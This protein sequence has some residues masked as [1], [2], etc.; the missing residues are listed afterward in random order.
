MKDKKVK[1]LFCPGISKRTHLMGF[2]SSLPSYSDAWQ[3]NFRSNIWNATTVFYVSYIIVHEMYICSFMSM[4]PDSVYNFTILNYFRGL[5]QLC[6]CSLWWVAS[7]THCLFVK[8][9]FIEVISNYNI[10]PMQ[11]Y[12]LLHSQQ[13]NE[14]IS[15]RCAENQ[16][17]SLFCAKFWSELWNTFQNAI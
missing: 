12:D 8:S 7:D 13:P 6:I 3:I 10:G 4:L 17:Q 5:I 9:L 2:S 15:Q 1:Y 16:G 14:V 11:K